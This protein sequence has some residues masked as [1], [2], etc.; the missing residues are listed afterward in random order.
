MPCPHFFAYTLNLRFFCILHFSVALQFQGAV[1]DD[2]RNDQPDCRKRD[3]RI[4]DDRADAAG[5]HKNSR[6][7]IEI[8][9]SVHAPIQR[10]HEDENVGDK[11]C[12]NHGVTSC[13]QFARNIGH[14]TV[15]VYSSRQLST[16]I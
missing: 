11:V 7:K 8:K 13:K 3:E 6:N 1:R 15:I 12:Y 4:D 2:G 5:F 14:Y 9:N 10:A 16:L